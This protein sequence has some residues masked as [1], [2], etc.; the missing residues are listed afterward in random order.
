MN[1]IYKHLEFKQTDEENRN[2]NYL[3]LSI[4]RGNNNL[5]LGIYRKPLQTD[6]Q[7]DTTT[8]FTSKHPLE[9]KLA[10]YKFHIN[11]MLSTPIREQARQ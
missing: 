6:R 3:D 2:I 11:R 10:T 7:T 1:N 5:Q 8:H 4:H 9:Q